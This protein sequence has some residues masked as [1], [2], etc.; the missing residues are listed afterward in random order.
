MKLKKKL[1]IQ[2]MKKLHQS[3]KNVKNY[4]RYTNAHQGCCNDFNYNKNSYHVISSLI[5][6]KF[7]RCIVYF[8]K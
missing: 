5:F 2:N 7:S 6:F 3:S 4:S 1:A 8:R